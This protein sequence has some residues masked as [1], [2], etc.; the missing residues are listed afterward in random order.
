MDLRGSI[1]RFTLI[2]ALARGKPN[3]F[4]KCSCQNRSRVLHKA[5]CRKKSLTQIRCGRRVI[6]E[7]IDFLKFR[8]LSWSR[9]LRYGKNKHDSFPHAWPSD[10]TSLG[11]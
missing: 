9:R 7:A 8:N 5:R 1:S 4:S 2:E 3:P 11:D 10:K 6:S